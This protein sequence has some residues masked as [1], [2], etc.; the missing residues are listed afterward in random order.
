MRLH[1][2]L[3]TA[4]LGAAALDGLAIAAPH[5]VPASHLAVA[6]SIVIVCLSAMLQRAQRLVAA[7]ESA[8]A[9]ERARLSRDLHDA[10]GQEL[11][12]LRY[13][14]SYTRQRY[15]S[16]P[17]GARANLAELDDLLARATATTRSILRDL[18]PHVAAPAEPSLAP[19]ADTGPAGAAPTIPQYR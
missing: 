1:A 11:T 15:E 4:L 7:L 6:A 14:L 8:R 13:A 16:D 2:P 18:G 3:L 12:A 17:D 5:D 9:D 10:L 19:R